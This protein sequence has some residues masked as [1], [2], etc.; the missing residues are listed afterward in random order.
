MR[1][2]YLSLLASLLCYS[3]I[4]SQS[5]FGI[6]STSPD[7]TTLTTALA[8]SGLDQTLDNQDGP[9]TV[10]A[11]TDDAFNAL[12]DGVLEEVINDNDLLTSILL[13][14]VVD[15]YA[16][17]SDLSDGQ[18][19]TTLN[20]QDVTVTINENGVFINN[21][22][23]TV[24]DLI[25]ENGV[26]HVIDAVLL[27][28]SDPT[29]VF[30]I[31]SNSDVHTTL[32]A[33]LELTGLDEALSGEGPFTVFAPTDEAFDA[34][35]EDILNEILENNLLTDVLLYHVV[36]GFAL[37]TDLTDGLV[38]TTLNGKDVTVTINENG[39]FIN[40]AQV[41]LADLIADN[42]VVHVIDAVLIPE[43]FTVMNIIENSS[44]HTILTA[45]INA[46]ELDVTLR[47]NLSYTVFAPTDAAFNALPDGLVEELLQDPTGQLAQ[48]LLYH[49]AGEILLSSD[50]EDGQSIQ[51]LLPFN[52]NLGVT[53][54]EDGVFINNV[55]VIVA[56][57]VADNGVVHVIDAVLLLGEPSIMDIVSR[58]SDH[59][60]LATVLNISGL[61]T[62]L[63]EDGTYT[64]FAPTDAAFNALPEGTIESLL[65][66]PELLENILLYHAVGAVALSSDLSDGQIITTLNGQ[67]VTVT[68]N[69][70]G[71]FIN[72]AQVIIADII[73]TNGVVHVID[74]VLIPGSDEPFTVFDIISNSE[75]H[76]TLQ[77][78]LEL[79]GL[80]EAL[81]DPE[82]SYTVFAP[83]DAAFE[84]LDQEVL[85]A[86]L[87]NEELLTAILLYHVA[88][89]TT[90]STDLENGQEITTVLGENIIVTIN[91]NGVFI[92]DAQVTVA[93]L[94]ADNGV[95]HVIDAVLIPGSDEPFTVF[96]IISNSEDHL[97]LQ[98]VLELT[99]L[100]AALS[101]PEVSY[102]VFAPTDA[103]FEAL[104]QE[105]LEAVLENEELLTAILLY[106]VALGTTLSTD[107]ENGQEITTVLGENIIVTINEN[108]VFINDA[109]VTVADLVAD[110]GVVHVIDAVLIPGSETLTVMDI[111]E[112]SDVH[113]ILTTAINIA[114]LNDALRA[115]G[116][117]TVFAPTD[118]A[119]NALPEG[120]IEEVIANPDLL[121]SI[122]L[123]H[124]VAARALSTDLSDGQSIETLEGQ[125]VIV[126]INSQ[127]VF[128]NSAQVI[129]ADLE[130]D[131]GVVHV[132]DAILLPPSS[133]TDITTRT[134]LQFY[135][136]PTTDYIIFE[137]DNMNTDSK[138]FIIDMNGRIVETG[139]T[140]NNRINLGNIPV[141]QYNLTIMNG[142]EMKIARFVKI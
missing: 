33:V 118:D 56:D 66:N 43:A 137:Y 84:A 75:D 80:D 134:A 26:V 130:A 22:L 50:L 3:I 114:G 25:A 18:I 92:N 142:T 68:I 57:L 64:L 36:S 99:G 35:D 77:A 123:Y 19:I 5:V 48:I 103:A 20:G 46:A 122:L 30:D 110:N 16:L 27:P 117:F 34:I 81:S 15:A 133:V 88:L 102:T 8:L 100:D 59:T 94:V 104:D 125:S 54:N 53:I 44:D 107:L 24:V 79:T 9:F 70:N 105:V 11:P 71:V 120:T 2:F 61:A 74:A 101:D 132:I 96:D 140:L 6:I 23:V 17:S 31:I 47:A 40:D 97:T 91:E 126:S 28:A 90:L 51:T 4:F 41:I 39:V 52:E 98:A 65:E 1:K 138:Y 63:D 78:V 7:H 89:G 49:V 83:T 86:V 128:I 139:N 62:T 131:N 85:E 135:P 127:G 67:D 14:H 82:V 37:S 124:V 58:S 113:T 32:Q 29:T 112:G 55:Q 72:E 115:E 13:Y 93:D 87:E 73:A 116:P 45:A 21:A 42:G 119:F 12:P 121:T 95:V 106:H 109:Q 38:F 76:L 60:L 129:A 69:E 141:G 136:N 10:F 111:I 108:G